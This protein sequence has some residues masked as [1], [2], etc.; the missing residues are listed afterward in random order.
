MT[1]EDYNSDLQSKLMALHTA[2]VNLTQS[3]SRAGLPLDLSS[4]EADIHT[5]HTALVN[6]ITPPPVAE[7]PAPEDETQPD[8]AQD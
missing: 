5:L 2:F 8:P 4:I 1:Q 7:D 3:N 6:Y